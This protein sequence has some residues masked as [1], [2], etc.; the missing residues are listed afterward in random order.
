MNHPNPGSDEAVARGCRCP[1]IDNG[2]GRG[3][4][5]QPDI[6]VL[7]ADCPL[8]WPPKEKEPKTK[9][10]DRKGKKT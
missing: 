1:V 6:F 3:Y 9:T 2:R 5:G 7:S 8:H 10:I 4:M